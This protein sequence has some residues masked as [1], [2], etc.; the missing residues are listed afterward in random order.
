MYGSEEV[1][2]FV[3]EHIIAHGD[4]RRDEFGDASLHHFVHFG[5]SFFT[6]DGGTFLFWIFE[7]IAYRHAFSGANELRQIGVES[8]VRETGHRRV[9]GVASIVAFGEG[10]AEN[11]RGHDGIVAIGLVEVTTA[12]EQQG[13]GMFGLEREELLHHRRECRIFCRHIFFIQTYVACT[14]CASSSLIILFG[15]LTIFDLY[16]DDSDV[17]VAAVS[18][19]FS[20]MPVAGEE[21]KEVLWVA[22]EETGTLWIIVVVYDIGSVGHVDL[23]GEVVDEPEALRAFHDI[24]EVD[25]VVMTLRP[26]ET[27]FPVDVVF[28]TGD[29]RRAGNWRASFGQGEQVC[30]CQPAEES[31]PLFWILL[32]LRIELSGVYCGVRACSRE[33]L[34]PGTTV[35]PVLCLFD[36]GFVGIV[37]RVITL[38]MYGYCQ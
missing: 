27:E 16:D 26:L 30:L 33:S 36:E 37:F 28:H 9:A 35:H 15:G 22:V 12:E 3:V 2:F 25:M 4:A 23:A 7:L 31:L 20:D 38:S 29:K 5:E 32:I 14:I 17:L 24:L 19:H 34:A 11:L 13:I 21:E 6:L 1:V 8:M 18:L 10:D